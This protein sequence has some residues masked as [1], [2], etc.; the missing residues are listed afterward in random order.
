[1][2]RLPLE[3]SRRNFKLVQRSFEREKEVL[4]KSIKDAA[5]LAQAGADAGQTVARLDTMIGRLNALKRKMELMYEEEKKL[6]QQTRQRIEHLRDLYD[7]PSLADVK[8]DEWSRIR[9]NR[10]L[11]DYLL[12][13]GYS[14]SAKALAAEKGIA[15]LVDL[16]VFIQC[17]KIENSLRNGGTADALAWCA[18]HKPLMKKTGVRAALD[19][20]PTTLTMY[21]E[22]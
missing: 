14:E 16:D 20:S 6:G 5:N 19:C 1:M 4:L 9:L 22:V 2:L 8:Y 3:L 21:R 12:R 13:M 7:I 18:E 10:L 17:H 15:D 11:V